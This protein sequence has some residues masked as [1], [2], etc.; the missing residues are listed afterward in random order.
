MQMKD[1]KKRNERKSLRLPI[2][3]ILAAV[4]LPLTYYISAVGIKE[5]A[6]GIEEEKQITHT[7]TNH[8][9][10]DAECDAMLD[11]FEAVFDERR[12]ARQEMMAIKGN[13]RRFE[14]DKSFWDPYEPEANCFSDE[15]FGFFPDYNADLK[16]QYKSIKR[17]E[18][19]G[20]GPKFVC[21]IDLIAKHNGQNILNKNDG[22]S[23]SDGKGCLVYSVGS[24]NKIEFEMIVKKIMG[25]ETHTFDP[26]V[27]DFIGEDYAEFHRWG[28]GEDGVVA[29]AGPELRWT[30]KGL[31]TIVKE[32]G[33][34]GRAIDILK[35]DCEG[36]E[37]QSIPPLFDAIA[38]GR[39]TVHQIQIEMHMH[40]MGKVTTTEEREIFFEKMDAAKMRIFHKERNQWG[41]DGYL[42]LEYAFVSE[43][44]LRRANRATMCNIYD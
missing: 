41:C 14:N 24:Q 37:W 34:Q 23:D 22:D 11:K 6:V 8:V 4:T 12:K 1:G 21:G 38:A 13:L 40:L 15:R 25:C 27:W 30:G 17:Y 28:I 33:H 18:S 42:C 19:F 44:F 16:D 31:E 7:A 9:S 10:S 39:I 36:C 43:E 3:L 26:T 2:T 32:L 29:E 5:A 35:I 20:D